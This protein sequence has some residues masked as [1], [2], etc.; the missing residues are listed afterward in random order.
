MTNSA[1]DQAVAPRTND[2]LHALAIIVAI[3]ALA[4]ACVALGLSLAPR[5]VATQG[6]LGAA[7][8]RALAAGVPSTV[9][10]VESV[11]INTETDIAVEV[12]AVQ[13]TEMLDVTLRASDGRGLVFNPQSGA[14]ERSVTLTAT[15]VTR[16]GA[17][18]LFKIKS[19]QAGITRYQVRVARSGTK[20]ESES[21]RDSRWITI[22]FAE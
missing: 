9:Q 8:E 13:G 10:L 15:D 1:S 6:P 21:E 22:K 17:S 12:F 7:S 19:E 2:R 16:S 11:A 18:L 5:E 4:V 14:Y 20:S 3:F